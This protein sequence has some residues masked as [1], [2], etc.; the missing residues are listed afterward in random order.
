M[1]VCGVDLRFLCALVS[2]WLEFLPQR[3]GGTEG[4]KSL[5][6]NHQDT[7]IPKGRKI[8]GNNYRLVV[9]MNFDLNT[10]SIKFIGTHDEYNKIDPH[11]I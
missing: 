11:I 10:V 9:K 3:H 8:K 7:R 5:S 6:P 4:E 1:E 2:S